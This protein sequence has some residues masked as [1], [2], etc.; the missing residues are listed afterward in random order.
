MSKIQNPSYYTKKSNTKFI[1]YKKMDH[2]YFKQNGKLFFPKMHGLQASNF[3]NSELTAY[4][5][6]NKIL[7]K[8]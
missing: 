2:N 7:N 4:Y 5:T 1:Y 6:N 8:M 3:T